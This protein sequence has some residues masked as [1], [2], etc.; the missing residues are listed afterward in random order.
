MPTKRFSF[1]TLAC[2]FLI[3]A[4]VIY[5]I[6]TSAQTSPA[7][8]QT[9]EIKI[10]KE[11]KPNLLRRLFSGLVS[12]IAGVFRREPV[13]VCVLPPWVN[14]TASSSLITFCHTTGTYAPSSQIS[15]SASS[16]DER[17]MTFTWAVTGGRLSSREGQNVTW[18]LS[19]VPERV[20][21]ATVE[22]NDGHQ[23][24]VS[25]STTVMVA[26]S[27]SCDKPPP[28]CPLVSVSVPNDV[29][30]VRPITFAA[31]VT[32]GDAELKPTYTWS[33]SAGKIIS[34]Q[35]TPKLTVDGSNLGGGEILTATVSVGGADPSCPRTASAT[36]P[37]ATDRV[38]PSV[39][40]PH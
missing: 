8:S 37:V 34:G 16:I 17:G 24:T 4:P 9:T 13:I 25:A 27:P 28:P 5:P 29:D 18:D 40:P 7:V 35:G 10:L 36:L 1:V 26:L 19:G 12:K 31:V 15:L 14:I 30:L 20:Y 39:R 21:T 22:M 33:I 32:G 23:H 3:F 2:L 11:K 6:V 38:T